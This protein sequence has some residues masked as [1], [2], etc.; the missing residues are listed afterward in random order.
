MSCGTPCSPPCART[1]TGPWPRW[2]SAT[3]AAPAKSS[4]SA[5]ATST[6]ATRSSGS[7]AREPEP[8]SGCR[9][10]TTP[11]C[12]CGSTSTVSARWHRATQSG[13]PCGDGGDGPPGRQPLNYDAL[14]AVLRR[15]NDALGTN[16]TMHD[17]RHTCA[18]RMLRDR[19]LSL[20]DIQTIL[21]HAHLSTT[22]LYL[23]EEPEEVIRRVHQHLLALKQ[24]QPAINPVPAPARGY[25][26]ADLAVLFGEVPR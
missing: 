17:L 20:R 10:A 18:R 19:N 21:G 16:W 3:P 8:N 7:G 23:E 15:V 9:P 1:V 25:D 6:G 2:S 24:T 14:R 5:A 4:A 26:A 12:G 13:G 22:Q 11:S